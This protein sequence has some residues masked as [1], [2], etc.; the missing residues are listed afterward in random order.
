MIKQKAELKRCCV[1]GSTKDE[2]AVGSGGRLR[3]FCEKHYVNRCALKTMIK[4]YGYDL[5][6]KHNVMLN[7]NLDKK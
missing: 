6:K 1:C 2:L 4:E 5:C 7:F 3:Y